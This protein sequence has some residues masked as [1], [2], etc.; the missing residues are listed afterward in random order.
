[1]RTSLL[2][3]MGI[4]ACLPAQGGQDASL[5]RGMLQITVPD[6]PWELTSVP[7]EGTA[8]FF[9]LPR[10]AG[11][12]ISFVGN[13][14]PPTPD[15]AAAQ[16]K[17]VVEELVVSFRRKSLQMLIEPREEPDPRFFLVVHERWKKD[18]QTLGQWHVYQ[19][20]GPHQVVITILGGEA[21]ED[22]AKALLKAA[23]DAAQSA[24]LVAAGTKAPPPLAM[25]KKPAA[26]E[27]SPELAAATKALDDATARCIAGLEKQAEYRAAAKR[28]EDLDARLRELRAQEP[29]DREKVTDTARERLD[30]KS[31]LDAIK[32]TAMDKDPAVIEARKKLA[33]GKAGG[34]R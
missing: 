31:A 12:L 6:E 23:T 14:A 18:D 1:M 9:T 25:K 5:A 10:K 4:C 19:N 34:A 29:V 3:L 20:L 8:A 33:E 16:K 21:T 27:V 22:D 24:K 7:D 2:W 26:Q 15:R 13:K 30:A 11:M 28:V 17:D 32:R